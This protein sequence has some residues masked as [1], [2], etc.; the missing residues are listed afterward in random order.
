MDPKELNPSYKFLL[1]YGESVTGHVRHWL[2][3]SLGSKN[4]GLI[5]NT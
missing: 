4:Q 2:V 3:K 1:A 5:Y